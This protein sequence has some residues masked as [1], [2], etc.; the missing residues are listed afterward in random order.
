MSLKMHDIDSSH[1]YRRQENGRLTE[2]H[3]PMVA[4][5]KLASSHARGEDDDDGGNQVWPPRSSKTTKKI[6]RRLGEAANNHK[7]RHHRRH[8]AEPSLRTS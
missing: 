4:A 6:R 8:T 5:P 1:R 2:F 7:Q 3:N